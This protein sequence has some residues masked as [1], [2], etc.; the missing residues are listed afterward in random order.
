MNRFFYS[1][2]AMIILI[3]ILTYSIADATQNQAQ[4]VL[5]AKNNNQIEVEENIENQDN[6][7]PYEKGVEV[8]PI[9]QNN[10][11]QEIDQDIQINEEIN[12]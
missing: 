8:A 5:N 3:M 6:Y 9:V 1:F 11:N 7:M 4:V 12:E 10:T 2:L